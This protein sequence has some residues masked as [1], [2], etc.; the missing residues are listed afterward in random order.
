VDAAPAIAPAGDLP[1]PYGVGAVVRRSGPRLVRDGFGPL[2]TFLIGWKLFGLGI[3]IAAAAV[4]GTVVFAHERRQGR[5]ATVVR[6]A[7]VLVAIR[8]V[9]GVSSGSASV[10]LAQEIGI[11]ALIASVMLGSVALG[12]PILAALAPEFYPFTPEML[13]SDTFRRT[14]RSITIAWGAYF[15]VRGLVRLGALLTL[16]RANYVL[17]VALTDAPF[18]IAML[19]WSVYYTGRVFR[20]SSDWGPMMRDAESARAPS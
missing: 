3:G 20:D 17:V 19:G 12:R 14:M 16:P 15:L 18:L 1:A 11:D 2:A 13:A 8:A 4:F 7:L 10:Y 5:P 6:A 9:V